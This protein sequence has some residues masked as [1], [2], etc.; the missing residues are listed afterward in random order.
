MSS[1]AGIRAERAATLIGGGRVN[2]VL[3]GLGD[4]RSAL[5]GEV[6]R[7]YLGGLLEHLIGVEQRRID[8]YGVGCCRQRRPLTL[9]VA[10]VAFPHVLQ[11]ILVYSG[12]AALPQLLDPPFGA[13]FRAGDEEKLHIR[14]RTDN[15]A[16]VAAI[17][18]GTVFGR[19]RMVRE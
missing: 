1:P 12:R 4:P 19:R 7:D 18:H 10:R 8:G 16:D 11:D 13:G 14:I 5:A 9:T 6:A 3:Q 15:R 17:E 2:P